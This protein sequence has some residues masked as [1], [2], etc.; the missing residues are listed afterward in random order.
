MKLEVNTNSKKY[1]IILERGVLNHVCDYYSFD[2]SKVLI[3]TDEGVPSLYLRTLL[4]QIPNAKSLTLK[5][6]E[7][8]KSIESFSIVHQELLKLEF[9]R[10][11]VLIAL[12]GGVIGDLTGFVA[13]TYKRGI[14]FIKR[15]ARRRRAGRAVEAYACVLSRQLPLQ[16]KGGGY[17]RRRI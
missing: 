9:S 3:I 14:R 16:V 11:D 2:G 17:M 13:S 1:P 6:G 12:G 10:N 7:Q 8:T 15:N 5:Q 4:K